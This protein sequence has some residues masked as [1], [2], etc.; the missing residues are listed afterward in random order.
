MVMPAHPGQKGQTPNT[1]TPRNKVRWARPVPGRAPSHRSSHPRGGDNRLYHLP[2]ARQPQK[3]SPPH[4]PPFFLQNPARFPSRA[5]LVG[6]PPERN[7]REP[8][9]GNTPADRPQPTFHGGSWH[10]PPT[11]PGHGPARPPGLIYLAAVRVRV[12]PRRPTHLNI[13][14]AERPH[15]WTYTTD[16]GRSSDWHARPP[17]PRPAA[18][19]CPPGPGGA[20]SACEG[21]SPRVF[22][23][24]SAKCTV[25]TLLVVDDPRPT[26]SHSRGLSGGGLWNVIR[27][28][29]G[30]TQGPRE[31][32]SPRRPI[33]LVLYRPERIRA[34]PGSSCFRVVAREHNPRASRPPS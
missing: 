26:S 31:I 8:G 19:L 18:P 5:G 3:N 25:V 1:T 23:V 24:T 33:E 7:E 21:G 20:A 10:R 13:T 28:G 6:R 27:A 32:S 2:A 12:P 17:P 9:T 34:D 15:P 30:G 22:P 4:P 29:T 14:S 16:Q 11:P